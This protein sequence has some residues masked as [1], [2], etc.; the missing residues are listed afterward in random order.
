[1]KVSFGDTVS[2]YPKPA[3]TI[4]AI[5][6][7]MQIAKFLNSLFPKSDVT[8]E[9]T[10]IRFLVNKIQI[11]YFNYETGGTEEFHRYLPFLMD[12]LH[13]QL[14]LLKEY[15]CKNDEFGD[16]AAYF[17]SKRFAIKMSKIMDGTTQRILINDETTQCGQI[18]DG[19]GENGTD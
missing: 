3:V 11:L 14:M 16:H 5:F 19:T 1:M 8:R 2:V 17:L 15:C 12:E 13:V 7:V 18:N 4:Q 9:L 6:A 10:N